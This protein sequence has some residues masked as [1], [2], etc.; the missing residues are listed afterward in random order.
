[1]YL[2]YAHSSACCSVNAKCEYVYVYMIHSVSPPR[3][4]YVPSGLINRANLRYIGINKPVTRFLSPSSICHILSWIFL[5]FSSQFQVSFRGHVALFIK[6]QQSEVALP[7]ESFGTTAGNGSIGHLN[8][9]QAVTNDRHDS[10][11]VLRKKH[12]QLCIE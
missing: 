9:G 3:R 6:W 2:I 5:S 10:Y 7:L 12:Q 8:A 1:M 11:L 4:K